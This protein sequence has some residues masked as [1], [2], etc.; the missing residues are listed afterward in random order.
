MKN[1]ESES[2]T[3]SKFGSPPKGLQQY[4]IK[5]C[6]RENAT[7]AKLKKLKEV[8][9]DLKNRYGNVKDAH[10]D[11][12]NREEQVKFMETEIATKHEEHNRKQE[13][14][15]RTVQAKKAAMQQLKADL[16]GKIK[17]VESRDSELTARE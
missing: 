5:L 9:Q 14:H 3:D 6:Q 8:E 10:Q 4:E 12:Q 2:F 7:N 11:L 13:E 17:A 15:N 16:A 1:V